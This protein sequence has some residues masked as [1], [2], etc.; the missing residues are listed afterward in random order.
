MWS[1]M[2]R[3]PRLSKSNGLPSFSPRKIKSCPLGGN[4]F[5]YAARTL[6]TCVITGMPASRASVFGAPTCLPHF[7]FH[8]DFASVITPLQTPQLRSGQARKSRDRTNRPSR[9]GSA[10]FDPSTVRVNN[11]AVYSARREADLVMTSTG[12]VRTRLLGHQK[13]AA[14]SSRFASLRRVTTYLLLTAA[15]NAV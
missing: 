10:S 8:L 12:E 1:G 5:L 7:A 15:S 4:C 3:R 14:R 2:S 13:R 11:E 9:F 6:R